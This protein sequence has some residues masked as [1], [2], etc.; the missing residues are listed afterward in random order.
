MKAFSIHQLDGAGT[1]AVRSWISQ[2]TTKVDTMSIP[3]AQN[4]K[5][6]YISLASLKVLGH[7]QDD[8]PN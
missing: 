4:D 5:I 3:I 8:A 7:K 2:G 1:S 6:T